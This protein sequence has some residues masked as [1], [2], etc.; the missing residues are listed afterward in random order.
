AVAVD[1]ARAGFSS[2][3]HVVQ[4][5]PDVVKLDLSLTQDV[6]RSA[7]PRALGGALI[8]FVHGMG[9]TLV[10]EGA[11]SVADLEVWTVL[12]AD[13]V[14]GNVAGRPGLRSLPVVSSLHR[15]DDDWR[16]VRVAGHHHLEGSRQPSALGT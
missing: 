3:Q 8:E 2:L 6:A 14:Q 12:G 7:V 11:E 15:G 9:A 5:L 1:D 13:A 10:V 16:T 4:V